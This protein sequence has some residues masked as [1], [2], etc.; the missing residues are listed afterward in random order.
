VKHSSF[1]KQHFLFHLTGFAGED[2]ALFY[3]Y[4][5]GC[6]IPQPEGSVYP[7]EMGVSW[8]GGGECFIN[9]ERGVLSN[10]ER[11]VLS[12]IERGVF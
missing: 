9:I 7:F 1:H 11:G 4:G 5:E 6:D 12:N 2:R 8:V 3:K 10:I